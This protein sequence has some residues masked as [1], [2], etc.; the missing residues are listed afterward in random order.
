MS[1]VQNVA[2]PLINTLTVSPWL[3]SSFLLLSVA[4][5]QR[6]PVYPTVAE[7]NCWSTNIQTNGATHT[8]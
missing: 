8:T 6:M 7:E 1:Y 2:K 3:Q 4:N 5:I